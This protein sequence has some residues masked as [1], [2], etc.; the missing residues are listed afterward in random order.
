[1]AFLSKFKVAWHSLQVLLLDSFFIIKV[2]IEFDRFLDFHIK[3]KKKS[4]LR[5]LDG[6][7]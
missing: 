2:I 7:H 3:S 5:L 1:M 4:L 6:V